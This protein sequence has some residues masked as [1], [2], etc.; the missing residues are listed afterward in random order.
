MALSYLYTLFGEDYDLTGL[1]MSK[2]N[3]T[4][5][6]I[7]KQQ[8]RRKINSPLTSSAGRFF[9]AVAAIT[10]VRQEIEY[11]A[12]AAID[13]EMTAPDDSDNIKW[14]AYPFVI[15]DNEGTKVIRLKY[16]LAAIIDDVRNHVPVPLVSLKF[17]GTMAAMITEM[18]QIIAEDTRVR[19]VALSGGVFQNRLL[20]KLTRAALKK[21]DFNV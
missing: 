19:E 16:L 7:V 15:E 9:D 13:L 2:V 4:E 12:Q 20:F 3:E 11:E 18:C 5:L 1:P 14:Q 8:L 6:E 17:H 21:A 10:G